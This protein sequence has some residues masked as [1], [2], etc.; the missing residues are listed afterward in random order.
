[1]DE[2]RPTAAASARGDWSSTRAAGRLPTR[3]E[4]QASVW[5]V[6]TPSGVTCRVVVTAM[7]MDVRAG[8]DA[9]A[10]ASAYVRDVIPVGEAWSR[11]FATGVADPNPYDGVA[12]GQ[13][14][15]WSW[16]QYYASTAGYYLEALVIFGAVTGRDPLLLGAR[17]RAGYD[18]GLSEP[19]VHALEQVAHDELVAQAAMSP[20]KKS[21][22]TKADA[23]DQP[24]SR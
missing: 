14:D 4:R 7:A 12:F 17:E 19:P 16:D 10:A 6:M 20:P 15:L 3:T 9:A 22:V 24:A 8:N 13:L 5:R 23:C 1:M 21:L 11:A 18:L 2:P